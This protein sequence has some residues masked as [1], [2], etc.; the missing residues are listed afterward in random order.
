MCKY[1][2]NHAKAS[3]SGFSIDLEHR[4]SKMGWEQAKQIKKNA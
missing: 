4:F 2:L 1:K 3:K